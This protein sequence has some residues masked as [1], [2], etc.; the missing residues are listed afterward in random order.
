MT[1]NTLTCQNEQRRHAVRRQGR[2]GLDYLEVGENLR[3]LTV[4]FIGPVPQDLR[5]ENFQI[6]GG[7]RI[8]NLQVT[9]L[10]LSLQHDSTL[11]SSLTVRVDRVGDFSPYTLHLVALDEEGRPTDLPHPDFDSRYAQLTFSFKAGCPSDLDCQPL[12]CPPPTYQEPEISYL[13]KDYASFR[14]L[15]LDRLSLLMPDW[16]E[17]HVPDLGI[18]LVELLAYVGDQLSYYQDAV[19]TE[20]Y[21]DTARQRISV[22]RHTRLIDYPLHEG[23]NARTW[24][25]IMLRGSPK[26][27]LQ[28]ADTYF[29]TRYPTAPA[30]GTIL[31][32]EALLSVPSDAYE[33]FEPLGEQE[34]TL[35]EAHNEIQLY[36]WGDRQC[37]LPQGATSATFLDEWDVSEV[38]PSRQVDGCGE[39]DPVPRPSPTRKLHLSPGDI[40]ILEEVLGPTTGVAADANPAH[41]YAVRLVRVIPTTD[42]VYT[43]AA[44]RP[45]PLVDVEWEVADALPFSLCISAVGPAPECRLLSPIS[46]ARGNVVLVDQGRTVSG[47]SLGRV[48][49]Q[50]V[51]AQCSA[52][53][54]PTPAQ[55]GPGRF[56]PS[57]RQSPLTFS[58]PL[59]KLPASQMLRQDPRQAKPQIALHNAQGTWQPQLDLLASGNLDRH[60]VAELDDDGQA[61]LRF[62]DGELGALPA[63]GSKFTAT[64]RVGNGESGNIGA[65]TL[66]FVVLHQS[67]VNSGIYLEPRH[68]F[69]AVGGTN[70]EPLEQVKLF[71]PGTFR[72]ELQRAITVQDYA[73]LVMRDFA[74]SVQRAAAELRWT[75]SWPEVLV[76]VDPIGQAEADQ[77][78]LDAIAQRLYRYR[79]MGHD[80]LVR[81]VISV[82]IHVEMTVCVQPDHIRGHVKAA[83]LE[84]LSNGTTAKGDKGFFHP[85]RLSFGEG[86]ALSRLVATAQTLIGVE[87]AVVTK[88]ERLHEGP[89]GE[90]EQG[91][92]PIGPLEVARLDNDPN[93]PDNGK[94]ILHLRGGR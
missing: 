90:L 68:L 25:Q 71:A 6:K 37:C 15:I 7:A 12:P 1:P 86:I 33:V 62:G 14:Q 53:N 52:E 8:R 23:C 79:R 24:V 55:P 72:R 10:D 13:A 66:A 36:T 89:N 3:S 92:L 84:A 85:D 94:L 69:A 81:S 43:D 60:F 57:L 19:A 2:N 29:I 26:E 87:N 38:T 67:S 35:Y 31:S 76:A 11:D 41:R 83:L 59:Q 40:L 5:P 88:L 17:R 80:V 63:A 16:Q 82:P 49:T 18:T 78:L 91:L 65:E 34:I 30:A 61:H 48:P 74:G 4:Y 20:A 75:G 70:P 93:F 39:P 47:E 51:L 28:A 44:G 58:Q 56:T 21:L 27:T 64:Y 9:G 45:A 32:S 50:T 22:R 77:A 46:V 42:P 54:F 73:D